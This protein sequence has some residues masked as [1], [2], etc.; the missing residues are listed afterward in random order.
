ML[1]DKCL[2]VLYLTPKQI[3]CLFSKA[4]TVFLILNLRIISHFWLGG[5][6]TLARITLAFVDFCFVA[7][8][9]NFPPEPVSRSAVI[10]IFHFTSVTTF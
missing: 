1:Q 5:R 6:C 3:A 8:A 2:A 10:L 4:S 7:R 9:P